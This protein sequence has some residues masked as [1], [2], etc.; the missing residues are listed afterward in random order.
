MAKEISQ[1]LKES[2]QGILTE[3]TLDQIQTAFDGAVD[4]RVKIHVEKALI[5]QDAEYT[6]K[7]EKL[8]EAIDSD[9]SAKLQKVVEALDVNNSNKLQA[10]VKKYQT[11]IKE[12]AEEF[13]S[14]LVDKISHFIDLY[15]EDKIPQAQINEAVRNQK[16]K[17]MLNNL[18]EAFAI[19]TALMSET[20]RDA[21]VD[22]KKQIE[23]AK[24]QSEHYKK[25]LSV[26]KEGLQNTQANVLLESKLANLP[27]N[28][29]S[30]AKRVL[31][32]KSAK[33]IIENI[34][35][36]L[37]LFDKNE[38]ERLETLKEEALSSRKSKDIDRVVVEESTEDNQ[39]IH[40]K[41]SSIDYIM[42]ELKKY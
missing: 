25:E 24:K 27:A 10:V 11:I 30:Y 35:Y 8:L 14:N 1:L 32:G 5:E 39:S 15:I 33:F 16:A 38:E 36:T 22:G 17:I 31:E 42:Q 2:T 4:E 21:I 37:S 40:S 12:N 23:E 9:H 7:L 19:D 3:E 6:E 29:R 20:L 18:R 41:S 28:K 13:K 26:V 34:D